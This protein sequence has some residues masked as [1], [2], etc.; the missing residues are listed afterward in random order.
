MGGDSGPL[1]VDFGIL[2]VEFGPV[3]VDIELW[4]TISGLCDSI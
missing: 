1:G 2:G 4:E 3:E